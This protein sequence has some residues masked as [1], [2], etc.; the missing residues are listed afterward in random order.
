MGN[1]GQ[2]CLIMLMGG[3]LVE[4]KFV[5]NLK[6]HFHRATAQ[7]KVKI[8]FTF[9]CALDVVLIAVKMNFVVLQ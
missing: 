7:M 5:M 6:V 4:N 3:H 2:Y 9:T 1:H 8:R